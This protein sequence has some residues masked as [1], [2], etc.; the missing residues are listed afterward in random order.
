MDFSQCIVMNTNEQ[1]WIASPIP[2]VWRK[3]PA[4][5]EAERGHATSIVKY[6]PGATFS[7]HNHPGGEEIYV[8]EDTFPD[9]TGDYP[10]GTYF[11]NPNGLPAGAF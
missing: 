7:R 10:A 11:Q 1:G 3:P 9:E 5:E 6:E 4:R 2:G 8:L